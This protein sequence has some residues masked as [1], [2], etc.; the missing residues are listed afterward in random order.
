[1]ATVVAETSLVLGRYCGCIVVLIVTVLHL[2][3]PT[4]CLFSSRTARSTSLVGL[5]F[6]VTLFTHCNLP[7]TPPAV[8]NHNTS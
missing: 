7:R 8:H 6:T 1:M 5:L 2:C 3:Q 4:R